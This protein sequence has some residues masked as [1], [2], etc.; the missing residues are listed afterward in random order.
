MNL[1]I[2]AA[3]LKK[4][5]RSLAWPI[6]LVAFLFLADPL[7]VRLD[8]LRVWSQYNQLVVLAALFMSITTV[9]QLD[10]AASLTDDWRCRPV[11]TR[12]LL[13]AK[14][15]LLLSAVYLP[16]AVGTFSADLV[17]GLPLPECALDALL[18]QD[19]LSLFLL[20]SFVFIAIVTRTFVQAFA[21][22]FGIFIAVFVLPTPFVRP[23][24]PFDPGFREELFVSGLQWLSTAP[25]RV[26]SLVLLAVGIWLVYG[27]HR[28]FAA[29][30]L[31]AVTVVV[32]V[33]FVA[34]PMGFLRWESMFAI[35]A[36]VSPAPTDDV[37]RISLRNTKTCFA[38]ARRAD[39]A[40][41]ARFG[42]WDD[43]ALRDIGPDAVAFVTELE[44]R[45]VPLDARALLN[46]VEADYLAG[47]HPLYSLRP[48]HYSPRNG[49]ADALKHEWILP[50]S[51]VRRLRG[52]EARLRL[53]YSLT[54]VQP[55]EFR[56][57]T[58]GRHHRL[59]GLGW[60]G[61]KP[62]DADHLVVDCFVP[63]AHPAQ[64]SA[65]L[66]GIPASRVFE[67]PDFSPPAAAWAFGERVLLT[68]PWARLAKHDTIIVT[69]WDAAGLVRKSVTMPGIL[70]G[71]TVTCP[72]P[73]A[74]QPFAASVWRDAAPHEA[75]S[76]GVDEGVQLEVLDFGGD[77]PPIVLLP[78]LGATAH[79]YDE[80]APRLAR[81]HR[82]IAMTRRGTGASTSPDFGYDTPRLAQ[83]VLRVMETMQL[84]N[85][86][87]VGH[88]IAGEELTWLGGHHG[89]RFRG[90][91]YLD[92]AYDRSEHPTRRS[93]V[94]ELNALLP[95]EPPI[96]TRAFAS[97]E[98]MTALLTQR[99]HLRVPEGELI[100]FWH[101]NNPSLAG[102]P[103][104][105]ARSQQAILAAIA[106]PDYAAVKVPALAI[107]AMRDPEKAL[108]PWY[109]P[110]DATL[111]AT[112]AEMAQITD[113][114][115]RRDI[116]TF[117]T[118]V[119]HGEV[120][121]IPD[122]EHYIIQSN[123]EEVLDAIGKFDARLAARS[124]P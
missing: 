64:L 35:Q 77:G 66:A 124:R 9:I 101:A 36:A 111:R 21:V 20:P 74:R 68:I 89:D 73:D 61:A 62:D 58:D 29:R 86:L 46:Y 33:G 10:S 22:Q 122:A 60:C 117:R 112:L 85:V 16:R 19:W 13:L 11:P 55:R 94:R 27:R 28:L 114:K 78:G 90:L 8:L 24:G 42:S 102:T 110:D 123:L 120:L 2:V 97:Y 67:R 15:L 26:A 69:A 96:P 14:L 4:D 106:A 30:I 88:S 79:S 104:V 12:E 72:L 81:G 31:L 71:D 38:A 45:G 116:D 7:I 5:V 52:T 99:G 49:G 34:L 6:S 121:E 40:G 23:P 1:A 92:A 32:T 75:H 56:V 63:G 84:E 103:S 47:D 53:T 115:K 87:L 83:D 44:A 54:L 80:L 107:Y 82:V 59:P 51:A 18:L 65:Q 98:A 48:A 50:Q 118:T 43:E 100:A 39:V 37:A 109:D 76:I 25:A 70:G 93:R 95:P 119:E 105:D 17:L 57:P 113:A 108:P 3:I 41:D 91:V